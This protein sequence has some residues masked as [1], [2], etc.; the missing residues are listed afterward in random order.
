MLKSGEVDARGGPEAPLPLDEV[1]QKLQLFAAP[2]IGEA[3]SAALWRMREE[4]LSPEHKFSHL[5][6]LAT[7]PPEASLGC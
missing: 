2:V 5:I 1:E 7:A 4:M 6:E 3:K